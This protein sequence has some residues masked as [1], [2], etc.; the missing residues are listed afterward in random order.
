MMATNSE[1]R[2]RL[3]PVPQFVTRTAEQLS[4]EEKVTRALQRVFATADRLDGSA[5]RDALEDEG[6]L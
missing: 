4:Q 3:E 6:L 5:L 1:S 2:K